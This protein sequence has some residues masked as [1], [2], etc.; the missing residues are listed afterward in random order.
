M[1]A[2]ALRCV[3]PGDERGL[4]RCALGPAGNAHLGIGGD[5]FGVRRRQ[6]TRCGRGGMTVEQQI[7][8]GKDASR[9]GVDRWIVGT[10]TDAIEKEKEHARLRLDSRH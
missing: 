7:E 3:D 6:A 5:Q 4:P 9:Q 1:F 8:G 2:Q 10:E